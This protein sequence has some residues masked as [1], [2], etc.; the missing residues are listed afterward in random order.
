MI[1][2]DE[3]DGVGQAIRGLT[4]AVVAHGID[5]VFI[6]LTEGQFTRE[7][8]A[9]GEKVHILGVGHMPSLVGGPARKLSTAMQ[10]LA[11]SRALSES[12]ESA[13]RAVQPDAVHV[14]WPNLLTAAASAASRRG[15][16]C[17][18]EMPQA[19][20]RYPLAINRRL[21]QWT[22]RRYAVLPLAN[23]F[24]TA[25]TL[26]ARPVAP[27]VM[28]LGADANRFLPDRPDS[29]SRASLGLPPDA[30]VFGMVASVCPAKGQHLLIEAV[31]NAAVRVSHIHILLVG[32]AVSTAYANHIRQLA[33]RL[34]MADRLHMTGYVHQPE[35]YYAAV[36]VAVSATVTGEAFGLSIVE[37][38]L[39]GRPSLVYAKG[40]A[41]ET[42][43]DGVTGWH[44]HTASVE[45]LQAGVQRTLADRSRWT[46]MGLAGR[47]RALAHFSLDRQAAFYAQTVHDYISRRAR[48]VARHRP[49]AS[50]GPSNPRV[51]FA[52]DG[53]RLHYAIPIALER[54]NMLA[55]F[56]VDWYRDRTAVE[57]LS[58][59]AMKLISKSQARR[60]GGRFAA[61]LPRSKIY[62][63]PAVYFAAWGLYAMGRWHG[64]NRAVRLMG[65]RM[66]RRGPMATGEFDIF[67]AFIYSA[68]EP[69]LRRTRQVGAMVVVDM[70]SAPALAIAR[71]DAASIAEFPAWVRP[72]DDRAEHHYAR[73]EV[74]N[75][76]SADRVTCASGF[77]ARCL[78]EEGIAGDKISVLPYPIDTTR[79]D[80]VDRRGRAGPIRIG[81]CG[82]V[83]LFKGAPWLLAAAKRMAS[84][85]VEFICVGAVYLPPDAENQ[86]RQHITLTGP[87]ARDEVP[88]RL[89]SF[90]I[91]F[92]PSTCEGLSSAMTEAMAACLPVVTSEV[93]EG[94]ITDGVDGFIR[95]HDDVDGYVECLERLI[96][97]EELR[98]EIGAAGRRKVTT[99]NLDWYTAAVGGLL[100]QLHSDW[101]QS[102]RGA[103]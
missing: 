27:V 66:T 18:W 38:M 21:V 3:G 61:E 56:Y 60:M 15:I 103:C 49:T 16:A 96:A 53:A 91:F 39:S 31:A 86:M 64:F 12:F 90:D 94:F 2:G 35:R 13:L 59:R 98:L 80:A 77:V 62:T 8:R 76:K 28:Q 67:Y 52:Q 92:F 42:V 93:A 57:W 69:F 6:S 4:K 78:R 25:S 89:N 100:R 85:Q 99:H 26:G 65:R 40:G 19:M 73:R 58:Y 84:A 30:I 50:D 14:V 63:A 32:G 51:A 36:D 95:R 82:G 97:S 48:A 44:I 72:G 47:A 43:V 17:M 7:M 102:Q 37:A 54:N 46:E 23:S 83:S 74:E 87:V 29:V 20:G 22:L 70:P 79:W 5:P 41:L 55:G 24:Y 75:L 81:F 33:K 45:A 101:L 34:G 9:R 71:I 68:S 11:A 10:L 1:D 88:R